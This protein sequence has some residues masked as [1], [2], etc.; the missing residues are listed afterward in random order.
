MRNKIRSWRGPDR[1]YYVHRLSRFLMYQLFTPDISVADHVI[2]KRFTY[3]MNSA[4]LFFICIL[5]FAIW[6]QQK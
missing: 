2:E 6:K 4:F 5:N 3:K 1:E